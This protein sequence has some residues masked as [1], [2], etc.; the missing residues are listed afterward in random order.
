[1]VIFWAAVPSR[2]VLRAT[3][4]DRRNVFCAVWLGAPR[5]GVFLTALAALFALSER[6][7]LALIPAAGFGALYAARRKPLA[8]AAS[9]GWA[10]Y[11]GYELAV[12]RSCPDCNIRVDLFLVYGVLVVL[13]VGAIIKS[14]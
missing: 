6:P 11:V 12:Q 14:I 9:L 5:D 13:S 8:L 3:Y 4:R 10:A 1:M 7:W 2:I